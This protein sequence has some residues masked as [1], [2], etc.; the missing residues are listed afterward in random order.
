MGRNAADLSSPSHTHD[1]KPREAGRLR[2]ARHEDAPRIA[3][4]GCWGDEGVGLGLPRGS[5][6]LVDLLVCFISCCKTK[7]SCPRAA[8]IGYGLGWPTT[9]GGAEIATSIPGVRE[10]MLQQ[11]GRKL[12][13]ECNVIDPV[14]Q[15]AVSR[16]IWKEGD[17]RTRCAKMEARAAAAA[18]GSSRSPHGSR[19]RRAERPSGAER[20]R[21]G[22]TP[23]GSRPGTPRGSRPGTLRGSVGSEAAAAED[24]SRSS[25]LQQ[26]KVVSSR[27]DPWAGES[28]WQ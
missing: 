17:F 1:G 26:V 12:K 8:G 24:P 13:W 9:G 25:R 28:Q 23:R 18:A 6:P 15:E 27:R 2:L 14:P 11:V 20:P 7:V 21:G 16:M 3:A 22:A 10:A 4:V 19:P 5:P